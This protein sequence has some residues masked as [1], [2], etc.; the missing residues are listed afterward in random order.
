MDSDRD[1]LERLRVQELMNRYVDVLNHRDWDTYRTLWVEDSWLAMTYDGDDAPVQDKMTT[2]ERPAGVRVDGR[3]AIVGLV[4]R[5]N[6][7]PW[8][9]QLPIGIVVELESATSARARHT[10]LVESHA[11]K[12]I[13][14]CYDRFEK[15][16]DGAWRFRIRDYRPTYFESRT[17]PG[18][19]TRQ[20]PDPRYRDLPPSS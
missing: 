4:E 6:N 7:Y 9:V 17:A 19:T 18:L 2:T 10:L 12:L 8:L 16:Q 1:L 3:E 14:M 5:Y 13:G 15:G 11:L 20:L